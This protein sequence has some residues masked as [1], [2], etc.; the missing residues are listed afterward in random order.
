MSLSTSSTWLSLPLPTSSEIALFTSVVSGP[1]RST[2]A[3]TAP[4]TSSSMPLSARMYIALTAGLVDA[5]LHRAAGILRSAGERHRGTLGREHLHDPLTDAAGAA[6]DQRD[7]PVEPHAS[8]P[9]FVKR[10]RIVS[11]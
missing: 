7:L 3:A 10:N 5:G 6:G 8:P 1:N 2:V 4:A 11:S 9:S